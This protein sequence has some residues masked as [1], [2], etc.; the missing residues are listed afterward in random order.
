MMLRHFY[1]DELND[2]G[3]LI[4]YEI[5]PCAYFARCTQYYPTTTTTMNSFDQAESMQT[6]ANVS[7]YCTVLFMC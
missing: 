1:C 4:L 5:C 6:M 7:V 3:P 2:F